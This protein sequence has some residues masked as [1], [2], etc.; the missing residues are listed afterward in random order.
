MKLKLFQDDALEAL[1]RFLEEARISGDPAAAFAAVAKPA[2]AE[3][4]PAPY[5][6]VVGLESVPYVCLRLP[7]GGGKTL[8]AAHSVAV[9]A[10]AY[11]ERDFPV[12]LWLVPTNTIR[13]QTV[14]ALKKP[15]HAYRKALDEAFGGRVGVYDIGDVTSIRP[16]DLTDQVC[17][18][19]GTIQALRVSNTDGRKVYAH[20]ESFEPHFSA[21]SP[22]TPGLDRVDEGANKGDIRFSFANLMYLHRPMVVMDEAHNARSHLTFEVLAKLRPS[23]IVEFTATPDTSPKSGSNVLYRASAAEVKAAEMIKLPIILAEHPDWR[24][25][26]RDAV[27]TR[28]R[29]AETAKT[30]PRFIRPIALL[31]AES[32]DRE[33]TVEVLRKHLVE[34]ENVPAERIAVATGE[35]RELDG[36]D[37]FDPAC[38]IDFVITVEALKEG[39][40]CPFAYVFS[41]VANIQSATDVEQL[42][43]RVLRMPYAER[44]PN[45]A[46]NRAY[47]HVSSPRFGAAAKSLTDRLVDMGFEPEEAAANVELRQPALPGTD[48]G[49]LFGPSPPVLVHTA[50]K[51]PDLAGLPEHE[52]AQVAVVTAPDG[53]HVVTVKGDVSEE[54]AGRLYA[55]TEPARHGEL[56]E[57]VKQQR[58]KV[59][60]S[61]TP[62][63]RGVPFAVPR[64]YVRVQGELELAERE[65]LLQLGAWKLPDFPA[66]LTEDDFSIR[67]TAQRWEID[68]KGRKLTYAHIDQTQ[69]LEIGAFRLDWT[70]LQL[71]RWLDRQ[72]RQEDIRQVELLEFCRRTVAHLMERRALRLEDL[73]RFKYQ[74]AKAI[75]RKIS[76]Y[77]QQAL[78]RGY[79]QGL[80]GSGAEVEASLDAALAFRFDGKSYAPAWPYSGRYQFQKSYT[81]P[82]GELKGSGEEFDCAQ[83]IDSLP[84]VKHW[85]RNLGGPGRH[86][87]SFWL[88][89][90]T[91]RFYPDFVAEL[92]DGRILVVEYKGEAYATNDDSKEKRNIGE[93]WEQKSGGRGLFVLAE[94]VDAKG[95]NTR[96]QIEAK[97]GK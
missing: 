64:L 52:R 80:F 46:L 10:K 79:Q 1:R 32:K 66:E 84:A 71:S 28:A 74:L 37:L 22:A 51:A 34:N 29:L 95:L 59:Q 12:V 9:A 85:I 91:D 48:P 70:D 65:L 50:D 92:N 56:R 86:E 21:V 26:V 67:D 24:G 82:V 42:L 53:R 33:V 7:T 55:V 61:Q 25:A 16:Q 76:D 5:R 72:T 60:K 39:W 45:E 4:R 23:C 81:L 6:T 58:Y 41:S 78:D 89:T 27:E 88:P 49:P 54:L 68:F 35:Q 47:A 62:A 20:S 96:A 43:G 38:P 93:L 40:D 15:S 44:R 63:E 8:L 13:Q 83:A 2:G 36:I 77:R 11:I 19:V 17:I 57:A 18:I 30:D 87:T 94:K 75:E 3:E 69:Q 14:E 97:I 31:Q 73:V 90:S